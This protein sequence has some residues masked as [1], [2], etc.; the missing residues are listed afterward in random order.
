MRISRIHLFV[1]T[2]FVGTLL[3]KTLIATSTSTD[4][5][6]VTQLEINKGDSLYLHHYIYNADNTKNVV[7]K[8]VKIDEN[9]K[10]QQQTEWIYNNDK[11]I[12]QRI[13]VW[14][15]YEW[16]DD[17]LISYDYQNQQKIKETHYK[18]TNGE[19]VN[20]T[21]SILAYNTT[22][23]LL[24]KT[25]SRWENNQ[26]ITTQKTTYTYTA[27]HKN[28]TIDYHTYQNGTAQDLQRVTY[29]YLPTG[30]LKSTLTTH[31]QGD[32]WKNLHK[33]DYYYNHTAGLKTSQITKKWDTVYSL[34]ENQQNILYQYDKAQKIS[35][36]TYQYWSG[37]FWVND[38]RYSYLYNAQGKLIDKQTYL[39]IH[40]D[41]RLVSSVNY[42]DFLHDKASLIQAKY[43][44][45][46][47]ETNQPLNTFISFDF[48][49]GV[50]VENASQVK[51]SYTPFSN[52]GVTTHSKFGKK[53]G[54][55]EVY[56]NPSKAIFYFKT[57]GLNATQWSVTD[58]SGK[59]ILRKEN[60]NGSGVVDLGD[61]KE[62]IY[63]L[64][65]FTPKGIK[66][67]KLIKN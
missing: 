32:E 60:L 18:I 49:T 4:T 41:Y 64:Q 16:Q 10:R 54:V 39:S 43:N 13:R 33:T 59:T 26:W 51:I 36:E 35:T 15:G 61:Y 29:A 30:Q 50:Q 37:A 38:V 66:V 55:I 20:L 8:Y 19:E 52:T 47:G 12:E 17:Y 48:N 2:I 9:W 28:K 6:L 46:G 53:Y 24:T 67:Q 21:Q 5:P 62:G 58:L 23:Q 65:V 14:T 11:C 42:T 57:D 31:S 44:F 34:W 45:W 22:G 63:L 1:L 3:P 25:N 40:S 27:D 56:P 7:T